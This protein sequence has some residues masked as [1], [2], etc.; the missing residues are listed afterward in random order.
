M[1]WL[2]EAPSVAELADRLRP[3]LAGE[4]A[5][6]GAVESAARHIPI[7][8]RDQA[9]PLS[10]AQQRLWFLDQLEGPSPTYN[11]PGAVDLSGSLDYEALRFA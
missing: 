7:A 1:R 3:A 2:F 6:E 11:M 4:A 10:F 8:P 5:A 9:L